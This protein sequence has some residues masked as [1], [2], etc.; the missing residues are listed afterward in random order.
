[1]KT[2]KAKNLKIVVTYMV[3]LSGVELPENV[4]DELLKSDDKWENFQYGNTK[5]ANAFEWLVENVTENDGDEF[6]Y[7]TFY[8]EEYE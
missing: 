6:E 3:D 7:G 5:Y 4:Y 8:I 2:K 1:M